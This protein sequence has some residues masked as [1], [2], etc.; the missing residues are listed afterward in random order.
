MVNA[1]PYPT[2]LLS[3]LTHGNRHKNLRCLAV[4]FVSLVFP[5]MQEGIDAEILGWL[6]AMFDIENHLIYWLSNNRTVC[7]T[8]DWFVSVLCQNLLAPSVVP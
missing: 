4:C 6:Q 8:D 2:R 5:P 3:F 7:A 1:H